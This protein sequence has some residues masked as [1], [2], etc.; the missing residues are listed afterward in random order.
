MLNSED[1]NDEVGY[2]PSVD[3][4]Q[5]FNLITQNASAE[6]GNYEGGVV[7]ATIKS[8]TNSFHGDLFEFFRNDAL[9]A[10]LASAG[11]YQG[12]KNGQSTFNS[13]G[14]Q[15]KPELR[16]NQF[17]GTIG[18][19]IIKNKLFFFADYQGQRLVNAGSTGAQVLTQQARSG[20][21]AARNKIA[22]RP[23]SSAA[24]RPLPPAEA[25]GPRV[26]AGAG[27]D[28]GSPVKAAIG[29]ASRQKGT[30]HDPRRYP[31]SLLTDTDSDSEHHASSPTAPSS[32]RTG[33]V[34]R[35]PRRR[36][37]RSATVAGGRPSRKSRPPP[38]S[39]LSA[40]CSPTRGSRTTCRIC[41]GRTSTCSIAGSTGS[42]ATIDDNEQAQ[43]R[44]QSEQNGS[45]VHS[46]EI[47][48]PDL[49]GAEPDRAAQRLRVL[50]RP[51][52]RTVRGRDRLHRRPRNGSIVNH[53]SLTAA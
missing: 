52:R 33:A 15:N 3:A 32:R 53:R 30:R 11:W 47:E 39:T 29:A 1:K 24:L 12:V 6:F 21:F 22:A 5:E 26:L 27:F 9:D 45:E 48:E 34:R 43:R 46:V 44:S 40:R 38:C 8:G 10:N 7:S 23:P 4:I 2:T 49:P 51:R 16:Y 36:R 18:G 50:P 31:L 37:T 28:Q 42:S 13:A 20:G 35:P 19:P 41:C 14:V 25:G 17:G